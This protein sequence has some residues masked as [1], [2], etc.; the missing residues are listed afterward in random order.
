MLFEKK[1]YLNRKI[2]IMTENIVTWDE[3]REKI[4]SIPIPYGDIEDGSDESNNNGNL[5]NNDLN[6]L[7]NQLSL[8][9]AETIKGFV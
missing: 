2:T 7:K 8:D 6:Y 5:Q 9:K 3:K 4:Q 1:K